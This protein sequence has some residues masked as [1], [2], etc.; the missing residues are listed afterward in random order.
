MV[1]LMSLADHRAADAVAIL[2]RNKY[3]NEHFRGAIPAHL[4]ILINEP[5]KMSEMTFAPNLLIKVIVV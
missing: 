5:H 4:D 1:S 2:L 3:L